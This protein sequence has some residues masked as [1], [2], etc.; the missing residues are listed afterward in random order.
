MKFVD[1]KTRSTCKTCFSFC[2]FVVSFRFS[3][4]AGDIL[5]SPLLPGAAAAAAAA[6]A[7][8]AIPGT[9]FKVP[10]WINPV[11]NSQM[12]TS[13]LMKEQVGAFSFTTW[14]L[15][16]RRASCG[17]FSVRSA[18]FRASKLFAICKLT[19]ARALVSSRWPTTMKPS[20]LSSL[21]MDTHWEIASCKFLSKQLDHRQVVRAKPKR[22]D[23]WLQHHHH[24]HHHPSETAYTSTHEHVHTHLH[25]SPDLL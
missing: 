5:A 21:S 25:T 15:T 9:V 17:N 7:G 24:N 6:A 23:S 22:I 18:P 8:A 10:Q 3:P 16:L 14:H 4:L 13:N 12:F 2:R 11:W 1:Q 19:S 20:L